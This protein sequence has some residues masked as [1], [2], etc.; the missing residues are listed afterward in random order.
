MHE[1]P[2]I[3]VVDDEPFN[4]DYLVQEL[5]ELGYQTVSARNGQEALA[6]VGAEH[7]DLVLLDIMMPLMD[8]FQV[9][10]HLK[11]DVSTRDLPVIIISAMSDMTSVVRGI[12]GGADDYLPKPFEPVLLQARLVASL[13]KK[14][15]HDIETRYRRALERE[16]EIGREIQASFLPPHLPQPPGWELAARFIPAYLV[17]GDFYD[18]FLLPRTSHLVLLIGDVSGKGVGAALFMA[19]YRSLL[20]VLLLQA[21]AAETGSKPA[22]LAETVT[23][24]NQYVARTHGDANM[25]ASL[26]VGLLDSLAGT[27]TY[28]NAGHNP[29]L[30]VSRAGTWTRLTATGS[31]IG[32]FEDLQFRAQQTQLA[33]GDML[34]LYTDG[35]VEAR[36]TAGAYFEEQG[37]EDLLPPG[38]SSAVE[39]VER[40]ERRVMLF[41]EGAPQE[42]DITLFALRR[43]EKNVGESRE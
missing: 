24:T 4:V 3:L 22:S 11:A 16:L 42:D 15:L 7:P 6:Q 39:M 8:G 10:A 35:V 25:F 29:P 33:F 31:I 41:V 43:S 1:P 38:A 37:L 34:I 14:R 23:L 30:L 2:K 21:D 36:N 20:R 9:L 17:A 32:S 40:I 5:E 13:E 26:F 18:A 28:V 12:E 27:L 19:L